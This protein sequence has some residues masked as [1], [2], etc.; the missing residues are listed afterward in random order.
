MGLP[1]DEGAQGTVSNF[2]PDG[3]G[4]VSYDPRIGM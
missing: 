4:K 3:D 1:Q 2:C